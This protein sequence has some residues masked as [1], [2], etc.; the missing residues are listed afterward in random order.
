MNVSASGYRLLVVDDHNLVGDAVC[1]FFASEPDCRSAATVSDISAAMDYLAA[2]RVDIVLLDYDL[3]G[4]LAFSFFDRLS[5]VDFRGVVL[6][7]SAGMNHVAVRRSIMLGAAG[8]VWKT[9]DSTHLVACVREAARGKTWRSSKA[10]Q[11]GMLQPPDH[12]PPVA[13]PFSQRQEHV[14]HGILNGL[15]NKEIAAD[16][17]VSESSVKCTVQQ[18]FTKLGVRSRSAL[19]PGVLLERF[20]EEFVS[21]PAGNG[22]R[23]RENTTSIADSLL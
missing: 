10:L 15:A 8:I 9:S 23:A 5:Q 16:L 14:L 11:C 13:M 6:M 7:L 21:T 12:L 1:A 19:T 17:G 20:P 22:S 4:E 2:N 18:I 3:G